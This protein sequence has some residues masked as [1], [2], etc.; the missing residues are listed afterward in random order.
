MDNNTTVRS[1]VEADI[2]SIL[3]IY[4]Q[5]I[6]DRI[7]TL[8]TDIKDLPYMRNWFKEHEE[9]TA[10]WWRNKMINLLAGHH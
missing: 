10:F 1:A 6:E 3:Q 4:N 5:G 2:E 9:A 7:T 8:E